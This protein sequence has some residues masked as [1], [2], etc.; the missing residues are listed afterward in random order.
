MHLF[1]SATPRYTNMIEIA[2]REGGNQPDPKLNRRLGK[3]IEEALSQDVR[4][5]TIDAAIKRACSKEASKEVEVL[6]EV[7]G[8]GQCA[9][10]AETLVPSKG[11]LNSKINT[12]RRVFR[13]N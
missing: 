10:L 6:L 7:R 13:L 1:S 5:A 8:P 12:V 11:F 3:V 2:V 4:R 9:I